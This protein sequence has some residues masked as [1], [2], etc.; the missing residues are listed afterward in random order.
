[1]QYARLTVNSSR[2][3]KSSGK[4]EGCHNEFVAQL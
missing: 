4:S 3:R 2:A 1:M